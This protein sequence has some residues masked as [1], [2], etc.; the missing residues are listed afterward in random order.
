[1][2]SEIL[3]ASNWT[4]GHLLLGPEK[5]KNMPQCRQGLPELGC[6]WP[7]MTGPLVPLCSHFLLSPSHS[8]SQLHWLPCCSSNKMHSHLRA[9]A[10]AASLPAMLFPPLGPDCLSP[11][12]GVYSNVTSFGHP[13]ENDTTPMS[14]S[15]PSIRV[16][17][18]ALTC[19][20]R[21]SLP[22]LLT[23]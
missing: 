21:C 7:S 19:N 13:L 6:M 15:L 8:Y 18:L 14:P 10:H 12:L 20:T 17:F 16:S 23:H 11:S 2:D 1:M 4:G 22:T 3:L 5:Q 9:F